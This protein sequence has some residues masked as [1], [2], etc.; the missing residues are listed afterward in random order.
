MPQGATLS[1]LTLDMLGHLVKAA[2]PYS[3]FGAGAPGF[4]C[5]V[6]LHMSVG[7]SG[8]FPI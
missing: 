5:C 7:L 6:T 1:L 2:D 8:Q 3:G 4:E